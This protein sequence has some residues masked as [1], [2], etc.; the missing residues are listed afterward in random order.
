ML[1]PAAVSAAEQQ[2]VALVI[3][4]ADYPDAS[5]PI[6]AALRSARAV[7]EQLQ[8][9]GF[10][11]DVAENLH[12]ESLQTRVQS[13]YEKI[14]PGAV[15]VFFFSGYAIQAARQNF[16]IPLDALI[17]K[18]ADVR[19]EGLSIEA[20]LAAF[21]RRGA[22]TRVIVLDA[23]RR[24]PFER[25]FRSYSA[26]LGIIETPKNTIIISTASPGK[27][28]SDSDPDNSLFVDLLLK[29][30]SAPGVPVADVFNRAREDVSRATK[31]QQVPWVSINLPNR[32]YISKPPVP[33][34][35][36]RPLRAQQKMVPE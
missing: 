32:I 17:W 34:L 28:I 11:V 24:N 3:G 9:S 10:E 23:S 25:R 5:A 16:I 27:V 6:V 8:N 18:E 20:M 14:E 26:G 22:S 2:R 4:N 21:S 29:Q 7:A 12:K 35:P 33:L 13:F 30:T 15:V 36:Q 19:R 1:A 31:G